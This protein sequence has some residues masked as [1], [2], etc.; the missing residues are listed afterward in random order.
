MAALPG[1]TQHPV[2]ARFAGDIHALVGE[3]RHDVRI[4]L[5]T[6]TDSGGKTTRQSR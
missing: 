4:P 6:T 1:G 2:E 3:H 5:K